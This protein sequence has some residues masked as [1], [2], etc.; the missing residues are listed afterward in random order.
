MTP[1]QMA[2]TLEGLAKSA[3]RIVEA[4]PDWTSRAE[5]MAEEIATTLRALAAQLKAEPP[6]PPKV[7]RV[8][9]AFQ[10]IPTPREFCGAKRWDGHRLVYTCKLPVGHWRTP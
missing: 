2:E 4:L 8:P 10:M 7:Q 9:A 1:T 3:D 6:P 5:I